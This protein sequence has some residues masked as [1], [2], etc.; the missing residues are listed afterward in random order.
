VLTA[1]Y[2]NL[3]QYINMNLEN[4][5]RA[6]DGTQR[7]TYFWGALSFFLNLLFPL[8]LLTLALYFFNKILASSLEE[9]G[10]FFKKNLPQLCIESLRAWGKILL[11][12]LL[13]ILPG[14]WKY[15]Q[16]ILVPVIVT[17]SKSYDEG[18]VDALELSS[19]VVKKHWFL[20]LGFLFFFNLFIPLFFTSLFDSYR[21]IW[22]TPL[23]SLIL[24][25]LETYF[26]ILSTHILYNIFRSEVSSHVTH[27]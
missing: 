3:D 24:S 4:T 13:L 5:L 15:I 22:K 12:S 16:Y 21:L 26:F 7:A 6:M 10:G 23:S 25:A 18:R 11:W 2:T 20:I 9:A 1:L 8:L 19:Q 17:S 27:V 14:I